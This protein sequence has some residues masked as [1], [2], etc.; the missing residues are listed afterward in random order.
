M[1]RRHKD[2]PNE[3]LIDRLQ[4]W[5][6]VRPKGWRLPKGWF[7]VRCPRSECGRVTVVSRKLWFGDRVEQTRSCTYCFKVNRLP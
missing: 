7:A 1:A 4:P 2:E 5:K 3:N 6:E